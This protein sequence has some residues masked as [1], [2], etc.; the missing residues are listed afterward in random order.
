[1]DMR[2]LLVILLACTVVAQADRAGEPPVKT[3][4]A[5]AAAEGLSCEDLCEQ[6]NGLGASSCATEC[7]TKTDVSGDEV[8]AMG[9][10]VE[11]ETHNKQG[12]E[13]MEDVFEEHTGEE[14][15]DCVP[16]S[17]DQPAFE[18]VDQDGDGLITPQEF[19][20]MTDKM[21][22]PSEMGEQM[23]SEADMAPRDGTIEITEWEEAGEDTAAEETVDDFAD[24]QMGGDDEH[25]EVKLPPFDTF[26]SNTDGA[27]DDDELAK[28]I[29]F[30]IQRRHPDA[31][32][33]QMA[34]YGPEAEEFLMKLFNELDQDQDG[35][36]TKDEYERKVNSD[37]SHELG[38]AAEA[39][40]NGA[41]PDDD[42]RDPAEDAAAEQ[43]TA[44][45]A[46]ATAAAE[47]TTEDA[48]ADQAEA[49]AEAAEEPA[50]EDAAAEQAE[51]AAEST[52]E[53]ATAEEATAA[54]EPATEDTAAEQAET[55]AEAAEEPTTEDAAAEQAE[56]AA[57]DAAAEQAEAAAEPSTEDAAGEQAEVAAESASED[58]PAEEATAA[59]EPAAE[60]AAAEQASAATEDAIA[61]QAEAAAEPATQDAA[62]E[63]AEAADA[64]GV[65]FATS[66]AL[67]A[68]HADRADVHRRGHVAARRGFRVRHPQNILSRRSK[69]ARSETN[70]RSLVAQARQKHWRRVQ[71][72]RREL[73]RRARAR[74]GLREAF[75]KIAELRHQQHHW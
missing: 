51:A 69:L 68:G 39:P 2:R 43:A 22:I 36:I 48:T 59:V 25:H 28:I 71:A 50:T 23:F 15:K 3:A 47:P 26:D 12:G 10:F 37:L 41:D 27:I 73:Q 9:D 31:T 38:E 45:A 58:A 7:H 65:T 4:S 1:M 34:T 29:T 57:E 30:E 33:E 63:Q 42:K 75:H 32:P 61:D 13:E 5:G 17:T 54:A 46:A 49:V 8:E 56:P 74:H 53:D 52:T 11:D 67:L 20:V 14:V 6:A 35:V 55:A 72:H 70:L 62:G 18:D 40:S 44:T 60:D 19:R 16:E 64:S 24:E 21:C 66:R